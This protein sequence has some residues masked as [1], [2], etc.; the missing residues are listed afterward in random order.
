[1]VEGTTGRTSTHASRWLATLAVSAFCTPFVLADDL[2][3]PGDFATIQEAI[4][5]AENGDN[6]IVSP[7]TYAEAIDF[8]GKAIDV[9]STDGAETTIIDADGTGLPTVTFFTGE[10]LDSVLDGFTITGG[11]GRE[12][13]FGSINGA[14]IY[15]EDASPTLRNLIV[16]DNDTGFGNG[17][18]MYLDNSFGVVEDST[19]S[20]NA[21]FG[22]GGAYVL[23]G[24]PTLENLLFINNTGGNN[25]GGLTTAI[26]NATVLNCRFETNSDVDFGGGMYVNGGSPV[27]DGA[28]F[29]RNDAS[30]GG[31]FFAR[32]FSGQL[33]NSRSIENTA[34]TGGG[35]YIAS[36]SDN[37]VVANTIIAGNEDSI[38]GGA[39]VFNGA[40]PL[41]YGNVL[42]GNSTGIYS[43]F[44]SFPFIA[45][46]I[47]IG[48]D[49]KFGSGA[50]LYGD[51]IP[52]LEYSI[53]DELYRFSGDGVLLGVDPLFVDKNGPDGILGTI[54]DDYRLQAGS[55]AID[56]GSNDLWLEDLLV[57]FDGSDRFVDD[58]NTPD[59]GVGTG[60]IID[61]GPFEFQP[62]GGQ[63]L[64]INVDKM[65][66]GEFSTF[67]VENGEPN[68][69]VMI[70]WGTREG[71]TKRS[72]GGWCVDFGFE[73]PANDFQSRL[74]AMGRFDN[75]GTFV[76]TV[77]VPER[78]TG[79]ELMFQAAQGGTC[80]EPAMSNMMEMV[81]E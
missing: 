33:L 36:G 23:E 5:A 50:E 70:A 41:F 72:I 25:G 74:I 22:G 63:Q 65:R 21:S 19:F 58:P 17:G 1:T 56:A 38:W 11:T 29:Y 62:Q 49:T 71:E 66:G 69:Q 60:G 34:R 68:G 39:A 4:A 14:G 77:R 54:D 9:R 44:G 31:G 57:D 27:I 37:S 81:V 78:A 2:F 30:S 75:A 8:L 79:A 35:I 59:T 3:V 64:I 55:P 43:S 76:T 67:S 16:R 45:N 80:P 7:G 53:I 48:N 73:I 18:G 26:S 46:S 12:D 13:I 40:S 42:I 28:L 32:N 24:A 47:I 20:G 51:G 15:V 61:I 52:F 10:G 6:V